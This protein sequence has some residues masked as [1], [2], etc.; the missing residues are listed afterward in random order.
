MRLSVNKNSKRHSR[1]LSLKW[2][3]LFSLSLVVLSIN[4][5]FFILS[6]RELNSKFNQHV[7]ETVDRQRSTIPTLLEESSLQLQQLGSLTPSLYEVISL[8]ENNRTDNLIKLFDSLWPSMQIDLNI[9]FLAVFNKHAQQI[10]SWGSRYG[11]ISKDQEFNSWVS[12]VITS[13]TPTSLLRCSNMCMQF[14][15]VP[16]MG[17]GK[18]V[19]SIV[20]GENLSDLIVDFYRL[21]MADIAIFIKDRK[22]ATNSGFRLDKWQGYL[23]RA[24][25]INESYKRLSIAMTQIDLSELTRRPSILRIQENDFLLWALPLAHDVNQSAFVI[26]IDDLSQEISDI[27]ANKRN[28]VIIGIIGVILS[29]SVVLLILWKPLS[30]LKKTSKNLPLLA[31]AEFS[32]FR[33]NILHIARPGKTLDEIDSLNLT[34]ATIANQLEKLYSEV[35]E[36]SDKLTL[37]MGKLEQEMNFV[38][39][40]L[41][42]AQVIILTLDSDNNILLINNFGLHITGYTRSELLKQPFSKLT[43]NKLEYEQFVKKIDNISSGDIRHTKD[44]NNILCKNG[45][46]RN[47]AWLHS[48]LPNRNK[49]DAVVLSVGLDITEMKMAEQQVAWLADHDSLTGLVNRR[50]FQEQFENLLLMSNRYKYRGA[51]IFIDLD[52]FKAINDTQGHHAGDLILKQV[53]N[54]LTQ[55]L[56]STDIVSRLGGDEFAVALPEIDEHDVCKVADSINKQLYEMELPLAQSVK[57]LS[58]SIG[59]ALFPQHGS[60]IGE[61]LSNADLAMYQAKRRGKGCSHVFSLQENTREHLEFQLFWQNKIQYAIDNK[62]FVLHFQ[63]VL[64]LKSNDISHYEALVRIV[65]SSGKLLMPT[66]FIGIAEKT[67]LIHDIDQWVLKQTQDILSRLSTMSPQMRVAINL[68]AH[69][70]SDNRLLPMLTEISQCKRFSAQNIILEITETAALQDFTT[71]CDM[72]S[73]IKKMGFSFAL[74]DFGVGFASFYY[75]QKLPVDYIKIDGSFVRQLSRNTNNQ[76]LVKAITDVAKG[77]GKKTIAEY[78]ED[79]DTLKLLKTFQV[80]YAQGYYIG[81]PTDLPLGQND[82]VVLEE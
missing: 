25:H 63:P 78:V 60:S 33:E 7:T 57:K 39:S 27:N 71:A 58:A 31:K 74:D 75:L 38:R 41:D 12:K 82:Y 3:T 65:D 67:G 68:S 69:A 51:V 30:R 34:A 37:N 55:I 35:S 43:P 6:S 11:Q 48:Y 19:G 54:T 5:L 28:T 62:R 72:I 66:P 4:S 17:H 76:T 9:E 10:S 26:V 53:A 13:E 49:Q 80:D 64:D 42:T 40:L 22:Q 50:R 70:F 15:I 18:L 20:I 73:T 79:S 24:S 52:D 81:E 56:R 8:L 21:E 59:I 14:A 2:K 77:F 23:T 45:Q 1:Q 61:L 32:K 16:M 46:F 47:V 44:E 29:E 36:K